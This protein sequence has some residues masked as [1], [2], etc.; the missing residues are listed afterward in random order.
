MFLRRARASRNN[1]IV[2]HS[3][4]RSSLLNSPNSRIAT[5]KKPPPLFHR[6]YVDIYVPYNHPVKREPAI[7]RYFLTFDSND[8]V[9]WISKEKKYVGIRK[10]QT[11]KRNNKK[12]T[13]NFMAT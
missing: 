11:K 7:P 3:E 12:R 13:K 5:R 9:C 1:F 2:S 10:I 6:I 8:V 4:P